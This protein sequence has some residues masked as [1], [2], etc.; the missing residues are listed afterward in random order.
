MVLALQSMSGIDVSEETKAL[1]NE[2]KLKKTRELLVMQIV[3]KK[4]IEANLDLSK[5]TCTNDEMYNFLKDNQN[6]PFF[7]VHDFKVTDGGSGKLILISW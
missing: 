4:V 7:L 1:Y 5:D 6:E 2:M 3:N